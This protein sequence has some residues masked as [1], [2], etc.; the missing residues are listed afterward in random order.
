MSARRTATAAVLAIGLL[1]LAAPSASAFGHVTGGGGG[2]G[3]PAPGGGGGNPPPTTVS[4]GGSGPT[5][6]EDVPSTPCHIV[7]SSS[8]IGASCGS[9][10]GGKGPSIREIL[11][12]EKLPT[13]WNEPMSQAEKDAI[14]LEDSAGRTFWWK[15]CLHGITRKGKEYVIDPGGVTFSVGYQSYPDDQTGL[16]EGDPDFLLRLADLGPG[17]RRLVNSESRDGQIPYPVIATGPSAY[18]RVNQDVAFFDAQAKDITVTVGGV[19]LRARESSL[20]IKPQGGDGPTLKCAGSGVKVVK[21]DT[22][23]T[24]PGA[25]WFRY[26]RSSAGQPDEQYQIAV[27]AHWVVDYRVGNGAWQEFNAFTKSSITTLR[28]N[29]IQ[30]L[31]VS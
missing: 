23:L 2:T 22:P 11:G 16:K 3:A 20:D 8:Y 25:C 30:S 12:K 5:R 14:G 29:E 10:T 1:G 19:T 18:P 7:S 31:V 26:D 24:R 17:Q 13:C 6:S 4:T 21:G 9:F 15:R 28:V 27:D